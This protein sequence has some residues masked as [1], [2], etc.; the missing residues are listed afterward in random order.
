MPNE[1]PDPR[2]DLRPLLGRAGDIASLAADLAARKR[3]HCKCADGGA[4]RSAQR[5]DRSETGNARHDRDDER[6]TASRRESG[7]LQ[8]PGRG[9]GAIRPRRFEQRKRRERPR[10]RERSDGDQGAGSRAKTRAE[11]RAERADPQNQRKDQRG[12]AEG[13]DP[14]VA[15]D[16]KFA[17][18]GRAAAKAIGHVGEA[19]L[20]QAASRCDH[21]RGRKRGAKQNRKAE[22][23]ANRQHEDACQR[24]AKTRDRDR[25][26]GAVEVEGA[27]AP[28]G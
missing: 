1:K 6:C 4:N 11:H 25:P 23:T 19:I 28:N 13:S 10:A 18:L 16:F 14:A 9:S 22:K 17:R 21:R 3:N 26:G 24:D 8:P 20:M 2:A 12:R 15:H 27:G 5:P 7:R